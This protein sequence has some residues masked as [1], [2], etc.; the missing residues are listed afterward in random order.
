M[1][2]F[3]KNKGI[4]EEQEVERQ[5][6]EN[7][8][9]QRQRTIEHLEKYGKITSLEAIQKYGNTRLSGTMW[10][11]KQNGYKFK[12][13]RVKVQNRYNKYTYVT[14]YYIDKG[15]ENNV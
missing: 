1:F 11:L 12:T 13:R 5:I 6:E 3:L 4:A 15:G 8:K 7:A 2:D 10:V 9:A 14:E